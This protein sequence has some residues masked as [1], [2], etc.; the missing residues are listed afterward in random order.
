[1]KRMFF[2]ATLL[3]SISA[4]SQNFQVGIKAGVNISNFK[5]GSF[6]SIKNNTLVGFH[7]GGFLRF[8]F[9][10]FAIQPEAL[11]STQGAKLEYLGNEKDYKITYINIPILAQ[12]ETDGGF[13]VEAGPQFGFK[14]SEDV[15]SSTVEDFAKSTDVAIALGLGYHS[16]M[17]LGI[18]ARYNIGVS[19]VGDFDA[20]NINPDFKNGVLQFSLFY[21]LFND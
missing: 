2:L 9:G 12:Y 7:A 6:D 8:K 4:F 19:N 11:V 1:M 17:G 3:I 14:I 15:P 21:T 10:N 16:K 13:Y 5:G 20:T 18:G